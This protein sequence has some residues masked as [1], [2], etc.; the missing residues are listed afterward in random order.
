MLLKRY[1]PLLA[2]LVVVVLVQ[3]VTTVAGVKYYLTQLTMSA[4]YALVVVGLSLLMGYAGQISLG[5]AGFFA[6]GGYTIAALTTTNLIEHRGSTFVQLLDNMGLLIHT[7]DFYGKEILYLPPWIA[8]IAAILVTVIIAFLIGIP[9]LKLKGHYLAMATLGF[10]AIIYRIV[11]GSKIFGE[12][13][14]LTN[15]PEFTLIPGV[16][17]SSGCRTNSSAPP[18]PAART[19]PSE[20]PKRIFLGFRLATIT[21]WRPT[22]SAGS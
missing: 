9:V 12:A 21:V 7:T 19:M 6:I 20:V 13:D 10:G 5:Q 22:S 3:L 2:L 1:L 15:V 4:Y 16:A 14:G 8:C 17:P 18:G 11:L